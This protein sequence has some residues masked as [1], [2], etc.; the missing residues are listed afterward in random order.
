MRF[1]LAQGRRR[2][3]R[4]EEN[5]YVEHSAAGRGATA[6]SAVLAHHLCI[7]AP[8]GGHA[9]VANGTVAG[10]DAAAVALK[11]RCAFAGCGR[12]FPDATSLHMH[13]RTHPDGEATAW[14]EAPL[15]SMGIS[16]RSLPKLAAVEDTPKTALPAIHVLAGPWTHHSAFLPWSA[17]GAVISMYGEASQDGNSCPSAGIVMRALAGRLSDLRS[18]LGPTGDLVCVFAAASNATGATLDT[19]AVTGNFGPCFA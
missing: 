14:L 12:S 6:A 3:T 16:S 8:S 11:L 9:T 17:A 4:S 7:K 5:S 13:A 10:A 18:A 2:S 1:L 15:Q 19:D